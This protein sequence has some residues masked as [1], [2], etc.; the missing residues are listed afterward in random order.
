MADMGWARSNGT[1]AEKEGLRR[2]A[3]YRIVEDHGKDWVV[4]DVHQVEVRVPRDNVQVRKERPR[5]WSG[6]QEPTLACPGSTR[7]Q[8]WPGRPKKGK[9]RD[10][11]T[12]SPV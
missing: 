7:R 5:S 2:G 12:G 10:G 4:L 9:V 8:H 11:G 6:V 3:W 1:R